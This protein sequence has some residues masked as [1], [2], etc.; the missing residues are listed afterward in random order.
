M[1]C[2]HGRTLLGIF[3]NELIT[4]LFHADN[5]KVLHK[6]KPVL[7]DFLKD[8]RDKFGQEDELMKYKGLVHEYLGITINYSIPHK[9]VFTI[10]DY[11]ED[12]IVEASEDLQH[13]RSYYPGNDSLMKVDKDSPR[14]PAKDA[15]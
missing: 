13:S 6:E 12:I 2:Y 14:L 1:T 8:L 4:V 9:V 11:L 15:D 3:K 7:D 10:F 5:L